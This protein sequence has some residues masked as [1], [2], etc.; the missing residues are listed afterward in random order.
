[1]K[2]MPRNSSFGK[3]QEPRW[4]VEERFWWTIVHRDA[5]HPLRRD[6]CSHC[7]EMIRIHVLPM[8]P[9]D[10]V[11]YLSEFASPLSH[12]D[13]HRAPINP[14]GHWFIGARDDLTG[15]CCGSRQ[16]LTIDHMIPLAIGD[17]HHRCTY[18][19]LCHDCNSHQETQTIDYRKG[20]T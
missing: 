16:F 14:L 6:E 10:L 20:A 5:H 17:E 2:S 15:L 4:T 8:S 13:N 3:K 12:P 7:Q 9:E 1:M 19:T 11:W 18:Q